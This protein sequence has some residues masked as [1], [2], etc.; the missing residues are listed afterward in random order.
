MAEYY[1]GQAGL[2]LD[3]ITLL[4]LLPAQM[5]VSFG[6]TGLCHH[7]LFCVSPEN[8]CLLGNQIFGVYAMLTS[9]FFSVKVSPTLLTNLGLFYAAKLQ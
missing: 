5:S 1:G 8:G 9:F 3:H 2:E 6:I 4:I 7:K